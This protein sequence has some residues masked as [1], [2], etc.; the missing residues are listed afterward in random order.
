MKQTNMSQVWK[1]SNTIK[2]IKSSSS[3]QKKDY[4]TKLKQQFMIEENEKWV[5]TK[6][7]MML[8]KEGANLELFQLQLPARSKP[9]TQEEKEG[10][11][12]QKNTI[13]E[14]TSRMNRSLYVPAEKKQVM[15]KPRLSLEEKQLM[16]LRALPLPQ[17]MESSIFQATQEDFLGGFNLVKQ[18]KSGTL[19]S[20]NAVEGQKKEKDIHTKRESQ[21]EK[22]ISKIN[23]LK[24][25][26]SLEGKN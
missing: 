2:E 20:L 10:R 13:L 25:L 24:V 21:K 5:V 18:K 4:L 8:F 17:V 3:W 19:A 11:N 26:S 12:N 15:R 7:R 23:V 6:L 9:E 1:I 22:N 16:K 14:K